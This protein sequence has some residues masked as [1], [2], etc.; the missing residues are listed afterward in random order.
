M[1]LLSS[2]HRSMI[3]VFP[4]SLTL[5]GM[6]KNEC[7]LMPEKKYFSSGYTGV[8]KSF[9]TEFLNFCFWILRSYGWIMGGKL[10]WLKYIYIYIFLSSFVRGTVQVNGWM[11]SVFGVSQ[12]C[13]PWGYSVILPQ[14]ALFSSVQNQLSYQMFSSLPQV[15]FTPKSSLLW[16]ALTFPVYMAPKWLFRNSFCGRLDTLGLSY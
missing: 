14:S 5:Q 9:Q 6:N 7:F 10:L 15:F 1:T 2:S 3:K 8:E 16:H 11:S 13:H 12:S 4:L